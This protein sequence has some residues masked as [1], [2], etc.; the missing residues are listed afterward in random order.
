MAKKVKWYA[1][2]HNHTEFSM[3]DGV[4]RTSPDPSG[5]TIS[6]PEQAKRF[7]MEYLGITDHGNLCGLPSFYWACR[8]LDIEPV[9]GEEF[10]FTTDIEQHIAKA[11][12]KRKEKRSELV[13]TGYVDAEDDGLGRYHFVALAKGHRGYQVLSELSTE[14]FRNFYQKPL[15]DRGSI[16]QMSQK[17]RDS[18]V[19]LSGCAA[20]VVS[21]A[22]LAD[23]NDRARENLYWWREMFCNGNFFLELQQHD[24][25]FD[26]KLNTQLLKFGKKLNIPYVVTNDPHF[27]LKEECDIH[28]ALLAIQT[29]S[30]IDDP[31]RF[32][33]SGS[34]YHLRTQKEMEKAFKEYK[35]VMATGTRTSREI[36]KMCYTRIPEWEK[37]TWH[38]PKY[39]GVK[40]TDKELRKMA[41]KGLRKRGL[42]K[43]PRYVEQMN[44][45]LEIF[46]EIS[47]ADFH[48]I[49]VE[50]ILWARKQKDERG[51]GIPVGPG[52]GSVCG[53]LVGFLIGIHKIDPIRYNL[54]FLRYLNPAR[55]KMPDID[56]DFGQRRRPELFD[57]VAEMYG[58]ENVVKVC[59]YGSMQLRAC[60]QSLANAYGVS[61]KDRIRISKMLKSDSDDDAMED[62]LPDE[63]TDN[64]P[65]L[66]AQLERLKGTKRSIA[67]HPAGVIIAD[68]R[69]KISEL[70]PEMYIASSKK[71]VGQ[72][73]LETVE[74]LG[75]M[76]QDFLGLKTLDMIQECVWLVTQRTGKPFDPDDWIPDEEERDDEVWAML[77]SGDTDGVF[78]MEGAT[79][80]RGCM[81][82]KPQEF[83]DV[84]SITALY[85]TGPLRAGYDKLFNKNRK[86]GSKKK[87]EYVTPLLKPILK[88]TW[89]VILYQEQV[90]E[91]GEVLAGFDQVQVDDIKEAIKHKKSALMESM[92]PLF[93]KGCK[94]NGI[95]KEISSAIWKDIEGYSG[96]S[97]NRSHAVAYTMTTYQTARLKVLYPLEFYAAQLRTVNTGSAAGKEKRLGYLQSVVRK[98]YQILPPDINISDTTATPDHKAGAIRFGLMDVKGVGEVA[99][100]KLV[101]GRP[102]KGYKSVAQVQEVANNTG[103]TAALEACSALDSIGGQSGSATVINDLLGWDFND[104]LRNLRKKYRK[105]IV[106]PENR[107]MPVCILGKITKILLRDTKTGKQYVT[108][109][110]KVSPTDSFR[111]K[112][113]S[114]SKKLWNLQEGSIV[115]VSAPWD[116]QWENASVSD[117]DDVKIIDGKYEEF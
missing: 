79:N 53:S 98:G 83:E 94:K 23:D 51:L 42:D 101:Q 11:K 48:L 10:Y 81:E 47:I 93:I 99:G 28:D 112:L 52:R 50:S 68:P 90:M 35:G 75:L 46:K 3:L 103:V 1:S 111:I 17:D 69:D 80:R 63:I 60:F 57:H 62:I 70:V 117:P 84:V 105:Q 54:S 40:D 107:K 89:G 96:Y 6:Y 100:P 32:R 16:E 45:E 91:I 9:L 67:N 36:A 74:S 29:A 15:L 30:D 58:E 113:W 34:G 27:V 13:D 19:I 41:E 20:S 14:S 7:G 21:K 77:A 86:L 37:R 39:P 56:T 65:E 97:Y 66:A 85:R 59:A 2:L 64:H 104:E 114:E 55:P 25:D 44:H 22:I 76:K 78:Q 8:K 110:L 18:L 109:T 115:L 49:T 43:D 92:K 87:V 24:C 88:P 73:D 71:W 82:V 12:L 102:K 33:F 4:G 108:W 106:L 31:N 38:L 116:P 61:F 26:R 95:S 5:K 72:Y